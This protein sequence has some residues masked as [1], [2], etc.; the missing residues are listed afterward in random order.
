MSD[1]VGEQPPDSPQIRGF[2]EQD[3]QYTN[4]YIPLTVEERILTRASRPTR[5][6][7]A[8]PVGLLNSLAGSRRTSYL[9]P[10]TQLCLAEVVNMG[11]SCSGRHVQFLVDTREYQ[12]L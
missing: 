12:I 7:I 3:H 6:S 2:L 11:T 9:Y 5:S 4:I 8:F 1:F 10:F